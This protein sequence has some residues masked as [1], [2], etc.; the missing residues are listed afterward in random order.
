MVHRRS[1]TTRPGTPH[2][3]A[4]P[5]NKRRQATR[6]RSSRE[7]CSFI[8]SR[9]PGDGTCTRSDSDSNTTLGDSSL[10]GRKP[11]A[12]SLSQS[13]SNPWVC[14]I[15]SAICRTSGAGTKRASTSRVTRLPSY[16]NAI[17]APPTT[18][19]LAV[20]PRRA[21][22]SDSPG[23]APGLGGRRV[24]SCA[25]QRPVRDEDTPVSERGW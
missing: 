1:T 2:G 3:D 21:S 14:A 22:W 6:S 15:V 20:C 18:N 19:R 8:A 23:T 7:A 5:H 16:A 13:G 10:P 17:A 24:R 25:G 11:L 12:A 4:N 9:Y